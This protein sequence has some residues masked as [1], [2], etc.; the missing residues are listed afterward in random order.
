M[1]KAGGAARFDLVPQITR[2]APPAFIMGTAQDMLTGFG[3]MP[4]AL[5][6][7]QLALG[8]ELHIFQ[9][10]PHGFGLGDVTSADGSSQVV[11]DALA[12]WH[13]LSVLWLQRIFGKPELKDVSTSQIASHMAKLG[14]HFPQM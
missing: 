11:G 8:Y 12:Q 10:G 13:G 14:F 5:K 2:S 7:Q 4:I 1:M 6:Y 3:A 9:H